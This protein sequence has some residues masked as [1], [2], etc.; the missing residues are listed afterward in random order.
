MPPDSNGQDDSLT[1][2]LLNEY[3]RA[4]QAATELDERLVQDL[5]NLARGPTKPKAT[6]IKALFEREQGLS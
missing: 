5:M 4:L 2:R 3:E 6:D 1:S